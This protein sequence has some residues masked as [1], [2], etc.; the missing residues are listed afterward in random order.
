MLMAKGQHHMDS[1][2]QIIIPEAQD[3]TPAAK[4]I[5]LRKTFPTL[6]GRQRQVLAM[7]LEGKQNKEIALALKISP[8]TV[9]DH[10]ADMSK[11]L[12]LPN[13]LAIARA[14]YGSPEI[15]P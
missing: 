7:L 9:E 8:R 13:L 6:S 4:P 2:E 15:I 14:A 5:K 11:K 10:R 3:L 1:Q 12:G